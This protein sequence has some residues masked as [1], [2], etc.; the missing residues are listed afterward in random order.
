MRFGSLFVNAS[1]AALAVAAPSSEKKKRVSKFQFFGVNESGAEFGTAIPGTLNKDYTWPST[2][3]ISTLAGKGFNIFRVPFMMERAVPT[4]L[5]GSI[6][7]AY[8][9]GLTTTVNYITQTVGAYAVI[10]PHNYARYYGNTITDT[11]GF[12][13]FWKTVATQFARNSKV[14]FDC[15]NEPH[16]MDNAA[17]ASLMQACINGVRSAGATSQYI[18]VEGNS[19][20]GAWTWVSSGTGPAL[21]KLTDPQDK[22]VYEMHQYLDSDGSGKSDQCV[23]A[24]VGRERLA[25][26][27]VWLKANKKKA[28]L[29]EFAGGSNKQC[30]RAVR[31]MLTYMGTNSDVWMGALWW[32]AGPWWGTYIYSMEPSSGTAYSYMLPEI[33]PYI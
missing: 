8:F 32:A 9:A 25:A 31:D 28:I 5:T 3:A 15:N 14:I 33:L 20:S 4:R 16:D 7:S 13:A 22:I 30:A 19:W 29:G 2:S 11:A 21:L 10:D 12:Q 26:A 23:S 17:V 24:T 27:T 1:T 18:F 6:D